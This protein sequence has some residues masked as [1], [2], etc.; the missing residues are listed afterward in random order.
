MSDT[1]ERIYGWRDSQL[2]LARYYGGCQFNGASY[3]I[4]YEEEGQPLVRMDVVRREEAER[5]KR[6]KAGASLF[7]ALQYAF[8]FAE[9]E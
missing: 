4:A 9:K 2:S 1:P 3:R 7:L 5:R 6:E 8:S